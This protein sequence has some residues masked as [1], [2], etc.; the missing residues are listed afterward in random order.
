[1]KAIVQDEYGP[2]REVLRLAEVDHPAVGDDEV[3]VRVHAAAVNW[4]DWSLTVGLPYIMR[5][6]TGLRTPR[7]KI[8]GTD[9]AGTVESVGADV[10]T[11]RP[12]DAVFGWSPG[13]FAEYVVGRQNRF[14]PKPAGI[15]FEQ[16]AGIA[17][18][19]C[20]ALQ[21]L[22]DVGEVTTGRKVLV[23]GASGGIGTFTVQI[24]KALGAE[25]TAVCSTAN[26]D[27]VRSIGADHVID[28]T[29]QDYTEGNDRYDF[30]LDIADNR[31]LADRRRV[32]TRNGTL[33]PNSGEGGKWF[34]SVGR[35]VAAR[36]VSPFVSQKLHPFLSVAKYDDLMT[37]KT[38]IEAGD[39][40]PVVG[41]TYPMGEAG[42][43]VDY[44]KARH[45]R[46]K[47]VLT[48]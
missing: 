7:R 10:S 31:S 24:A 3:L 20:V 4:A 29:Q 23:N 43:A 1:M 25:V 27:L 22:R 35:I 30:I 32:L 42:E 48:M 13:S 9:V 18:A 33:V 39:V 44:C 41:R 36:L 11:L 38:M 46:G 26:L 34:A 5:L 16:A 37:L 19:G 15:T 17:M 45:G 21:A 6:G 40:T 8:R 14:V 12:G 28:Y 2:P 47:T